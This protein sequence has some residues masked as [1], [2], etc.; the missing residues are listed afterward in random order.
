M[1]V[2]WTVT[3]P[4]KG[5]RPRRDQLSG[6]LKLTERILDSTSKVGRKRQGKDGHHLSALRVGGVRHFCS[7]MWL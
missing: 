7:C 2:L 4:T 6:V 3:S 5:A 1:P